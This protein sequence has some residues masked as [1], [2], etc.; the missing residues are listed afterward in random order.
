MYDFFDTPFELFRYRASR[1]IMC[2][3]LS[4]RILDAGVG[5]G[6]DLPYFGPNAEVT[7]IDLSEGMLR[8]AGRR[9]SR[10]RAKI[11]LKIMDATRLEYPD[12]Y[13]DACVATFMFCTLPDELQMPVLKELL[14]VTKPGG[15]VR[16]LEHRFS[17]RWWR[18]L[19]MKSFAPIVKWAY[20]SRYDHTIG[21]AVKASGAKVVEE[22]FVASDIVKMYVLEPATKGAS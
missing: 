9:I 2:G 8:R 18:R 13:F 14:R 21:E 15:Q 4:G 10:C 12:G 17:Q 20:H 6:K 7:G 3:D 19:H 22:R 11:E 16:I 1:R 5:T